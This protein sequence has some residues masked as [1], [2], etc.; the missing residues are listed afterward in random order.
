MTEK[1]DAI[2]SIATHRKRFDVCLKTLEKVFAQT[3]KPE[4]IIVNVYKDEMPDLPD[5]YRKLEAEGKIEI[6]ECP[7][8]LRPHNK[9]WW[10]M[11]RFP[12]NPVLTLDDDIEYEPDILENLYASYKRNPENVHSYRFHEMT[13]GADGR[14]KT[15]RLWKF[16]IDKATN[17]NVYATG[18]SGILYPP[19]FLSKM[20]EEELKSAVLKHITVDDI[21]LTWIRI[22]CGISATVVPSRCKLPR[23]VDQRHGLC[24]NENAGHHNNDIC[25]QDLIQPMYPVRNNPTPR[26]NY[27]D[28]DMTDDD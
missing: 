4:R 5:E 8:D 3:L 26:F 6:Y 27:S 17:N 16:E 19:K 11:H 21:V 22:K 18:C 12:E 28:W 23:A 9:Y 15:Y 25:V 1:C 20:D 7:E 2:I 13:F 24:T 14:I 10:T